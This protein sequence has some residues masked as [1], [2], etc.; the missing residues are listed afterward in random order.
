[1]VLVRPRDAIARGARVITARYQMGRVLGKPGGFGVT[2][3]AWDLHL[4]RRV[5]IKEFFPQGM[6][7]RAADG[8]VE[9]PAPEERDAFEAG[10]RSF[11]DEARIVAECQHDGIVS[12]IDFAED[13]GS[14]YIVM[15]YYEGQSLD[16]YLRSKGGRIGWIEATRI[17]LAVLDGLE[18]VHAAGLIHRDIKPQNIY[19]THDARGGTRPILLDFGAARRTA[20]SRK[21]TV[22]LSEEFAPIEQYNVGFEQGPWTDVYAAA[23]TLYTMI[24]GAPPP[25]AIK[26]LEASALTPAHILVSGVPSTLS[27][28]LAQGL[29]MDAVQRPGS[30]KVFAELLRGVLTGAEGRVHAPSKAG[31]PRPRPSAPTMRVPERFNLRSS[32]E[33]EVEPVETGR[34]TRRFILYTAAAVIVLMIAAGAVRQARPSRGG[35]VVG[36]AT[37]TNASPAPG[38]IAPVGLGAPPSVSTPADSSGTARDTASTREASALA[39]LRQSLEITR[40]LFGGG[41]FA[42]AASAARL[43]A[44]NA[45]A[46]ARRYPA[47]NAAFERI[48]TDAS[49]LEADARRRCVAAQRAAGQSDQTGSCQP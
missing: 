4:Q 40:V 19:L 34:G 14:A 45:A 7:A 3:L 35:A 44:Q 41:S 46:D 43:V 37:Q 23:G 17:M 9:P 31:G 27:A 21:M 49:E 10:L 39:E 24:T 16:A 6:A 48:A 5:A 42:Q 26:R 8:A 11:L 38:T 33:G 32:E 47:N 30:A 22:V 25:P 20:G 1:V 18:S 2:Y 28:A 29:A 12:V 36:T 13:N 15:H